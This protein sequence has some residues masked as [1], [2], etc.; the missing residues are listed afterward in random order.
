MLVWVVTTTV[1]NQSHNGLHTCVRPA[2][3]AAAQSM[4]YVCV[5]D[6]LLS[7]RRVSNLGGGRHALL[8]FFSCIVVSDTFGSCRVALD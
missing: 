6:R 1:H 8:I 7:S 5:D 3:A 2:S 4:G